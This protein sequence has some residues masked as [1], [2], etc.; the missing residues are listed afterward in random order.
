MVLFSFI[1]ELL[2]QVLKTILL[3][4]HAHLVCTTYEREHIVFSSS[5]GIHAQITKGKGKYNYGNSLSVS[6]IILLL[7]QNIIS[8][9]EASTNFLGRKPFP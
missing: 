3:I 4:T 1:L 5:D 2:R 6:E 7:K 9:K 8:T